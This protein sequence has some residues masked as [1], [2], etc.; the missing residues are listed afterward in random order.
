MRGRVIGSNGCE[1]RTWNKSRTSVLCRSEA[2]PMGKTMRFC[3]QRWQL[4]SAGRLMKEVAEYI[5]SLRSVAFGSEQYL[6]AK[7]V[8]VVLS[9]SI[10]TLALSRTPASSAG[11]PQD[12]RCANIWSRGQ[13]RYATM[14]QKAQWL[15]RLF[16]RSTDFGQERLCTRTGASPSVQGVRRRWA[17]QP[18][19]EGG[20]R[21]K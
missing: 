2:R 19:G 11:Q 7:R 13:C 17:H 8:G 14:L 15:S 1:A 12:S 10:L 18:L 21:L 3:Q 9:Y 4:A 5:S 16:F 20:S 6:A